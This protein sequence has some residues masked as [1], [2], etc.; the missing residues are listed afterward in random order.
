MSNENQPIST[1]KT[2]NLAQRILQVYEEVDTVIKDD[3][4]S[5]GGE[6]YSAVT[7]DAVTRLLHQ[8]IA[9][10]RIVVV[11]TQETF[12]LSDFEAKNRY[13]DLKRSYKV[14][15]KVTATFINADDPADRLSSSAWGY[16]LDSSD[17]AMGKAYSY[18]LKNIYLKVFLL[19]SRDH[20]EQRTFEEDLRRFQEAKPDGST[21]KAE[22]RPNGHQKGGNRNQGNGG[23]KVIPPAKANVIPPAGATAAGP[24][25]T[26]A[27]ASSDLREAMKRIP[28]KK[29][30][31]RQS[32][33]TP[34]EFRITWGPHYEGKKLGELTKEQI[35]KYMWILQERARTDKIAITPGGP[36]E[37]FF[38]CALKLLGDDVNAPAVSDPVDHP[39]YPG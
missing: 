19:E 10:A 2:L 5:T 1:S 12:E 3:S 21:A 30:Y 8:P 24:A 16:A 22:N 28:E 17:K 39:Q 13:G 14:T 31:V 25:K 15:M 7:H 32:P 18:A 29:P 38:E 11:P 35:E 26:V 4:V 37:E 9:R 20:E 23:G 27:Q 34:G 36:V 33:A 6:S